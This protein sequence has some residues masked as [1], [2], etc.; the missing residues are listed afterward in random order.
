MEFGLFLFESK[1]DSGQFEDD[2]ETQPSFEQS[3]GDFQT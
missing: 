3:N 2:F 1:K